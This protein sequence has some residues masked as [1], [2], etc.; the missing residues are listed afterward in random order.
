[1]EILSRDEMEQRRMEAA[2]KLLEGMRPWRVAAR[3]G[4]SRPTVTR[5]RRTLTTGGVESLMKR[6]A[7][8]RPSRLT[9]EQKAQF[10][11]W[12]GLGPAA[13]GQSPDKWTCARLGQLIEE[14]F[15]IHYHPDYIRRLVVRMSPRH[16]AEGRMRPMDYGAPEPAGELAELIPGSSHSR[17][18]AR[19]IRSGTGRETNPEA[20]V[21]TRQDR[22]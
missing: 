8:G 11:K 10:A 13:L 3:F 5:W 20:K 9:V 2:K 22:A 16:A 17:R 4:V 7:P 19:L 12:V 21:D 15:G 6:V 1:M 18:L 14:R